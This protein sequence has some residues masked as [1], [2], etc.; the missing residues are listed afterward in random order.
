MSN[1]TG[2]IILAAGSSSRMGQPKQ[3]LEFR[4]E[5][6]M[7]RAVRIALSTGVEPVI[8]VL[9]A[10]ADRVKEAVP[11]RAAVNVVYNEDWPLGMS[12]SLRSGVRYAMKYF[13]NLQALLFIVV[14][15]PFVTSDLLSLLLAAYRDS[16]ALIVAARY[17]GTPGVPALFDRCLFNEML[18]LEGDQGARP[19]FEKYRHKLQTVP[20]PAG[21]FDLDTP[22]DFDRLMEEE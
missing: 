2:I 5:S 9:G 12:S 16:R 1:Q 8:V 18:A 15:Q 20:F 3:L 14:D 22:D 4:G 13:P 19:L 6:M 7:H 21:R 17:Q 11:Q 10:E